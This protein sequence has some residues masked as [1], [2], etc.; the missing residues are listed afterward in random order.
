VPIEVNQSPV[1]PDQPVITKYLNHIY[2]ALT[3]Y[4]GETNEDFDDVYLSINNA[5]VDNW[6]TLQTVTPATDAVT[7]LF[8]VAEAYTSG[9]LVVYRDGAILFRGLDYTET[10]PSSGTFTLNTAPD[11]DEDLR[12]SYVAA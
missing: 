9:T 4:Q 10:S 8:T 5:S 7:V 3:N 1:I 12:V 11:A 6:K 2:L